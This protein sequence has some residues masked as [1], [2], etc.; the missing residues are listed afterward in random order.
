MTIIL[1]LFKILFY[2]IFLIIILIEN[3]FL[4]MLALFK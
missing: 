3:H 2:F 4:Y 1:N